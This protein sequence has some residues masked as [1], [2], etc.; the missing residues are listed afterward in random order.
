MRIKNEYHVG[1]FDVGTC[2]TFT[3]E[4]LSILREYVFE[5]LLPL[6]EEF[7]ETAIKYMN[8][9]MEQGQKNNET[10]NF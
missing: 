2:V 8:Y 3:R 4:Q 5:S 1:T 10:K 9:Q 6:S 7:M